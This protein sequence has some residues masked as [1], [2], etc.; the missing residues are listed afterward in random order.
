MTCECECPNDRARS[1]K[2]SQA[3]R[4]ARHFARDFAEISSY[5]SINFSISELDHFLFPFPSFP[6]TFSVKTKMVS[7]LFGTF[8]S[9]FSL[10]FEATFVDVFRELHQ[11]ACTK[12]P[13]VYGFHGNWP[14]KIFLSLH[15]RSNTSQAFAS[16]K[17]LAMKF[18][19]VQIVRKSTQAIASW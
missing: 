7:L 19:P 11:S 4:I 5:S 14:R 12:G 2:V 17:K 9:I 16:L 13:G 3:V 6:L 10:F 15:F 1:R 18:E 8:S